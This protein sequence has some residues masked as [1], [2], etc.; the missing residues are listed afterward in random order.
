LAWLLLFLTFGVSNY[1]MVPSERK[2]AMFK[3]M[4][5][6]LG[7][8]AAVGVFGVQ[9]ASAGH[10]HHGGHHHHHGGASLSIYGGY[11]YGYP[12][13]P[14]PVYPRPVYPAPVYPPVVVPA[15]PPAP[16]PCLHGPVY[17]PAYGP[18]YG[19]GV[20]YSNRNFSLWLGR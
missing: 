16:A 19:G 12:A 10:E 20:G 1:R 7:T 8:A 9:T 2:P 11:P 5:C 3:S 15:Y 14:R 13:Y 17:A 18:A 6:G 4:L